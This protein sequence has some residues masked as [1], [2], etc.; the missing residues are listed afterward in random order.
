MF[1]HKTN[2]Q[3]QT[4][5]E[6]MIITLIVLTVSILIISSFSQVN[7]STSAIVILR[8]VSVTE[9]T[10]ASS[11]FYLEK[12]EGPVVDVD[13]KPN[14]VIKISGNKLITPDL[15]NRIETRSVNALVNAGI[16][17]EAQVKVQQV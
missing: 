5:I 8:E 9:L 16:Y 3:G 7:S 4:S 6:F 10:S 1:K 15:K 13:N 12:V 14:F 17:E 11:F 2:S